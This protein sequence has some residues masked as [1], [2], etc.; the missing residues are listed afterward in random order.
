M[1]LGQQMHWQGQH[2]PSTMKTVSSFASFIA[3]FGFH[4]LHLKNAM[5]HNTQV[6]T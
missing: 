4:P 3:Y 1:S 2:G 6:Q 5:P